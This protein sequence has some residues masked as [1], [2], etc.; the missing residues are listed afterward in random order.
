MTQTPVPQGEY[1]PYY[2]KIEVHWDRIPLWFSD[3][4]QIIVE[5]YGW[6]RDP[7]HAELLLERINAFLWLMGVFGLALS[8]PDSTDSEAPSGTLLDLPLFRGIVSTPTEG[9]VGVLAGLSVRR[10]DDPGNATNSGLAIEPYV[11]GSFDLPI[12]LTEGWN[13]AIGAELGAQGLALTIQPS[14]ANIVLAGG[15]GA[16]LRVG[17]QRDGTLLG[18]LLLFGN[19]G[20]TRLEIAQVGIALTASASTGGSPDV[21][22]EIPTQGFQLVIV[23]SEGDGFLKTVLPAEPLII[24]FDLMIGASLKRGVYFSGGAGFDYTFNINK[25]V[26]AIFVDSIDLGLKLDAKG[27][28]LSVGATGGLELGPVVAVIQG[29]GIQIK[30]TFGQRGNLGNA[31]LGILFKPPTGIGLSIDTPT[32]KAGGFLSIDVDRGRYVGA[33]ELSILN[34]FDLAAIAIITT[35]SPDG[36]PGFSLLFLIS[37]TLPVPVPLGYNFYFAGAGGLLGLNRGVDIDYLREGLR[38]GT[39]DNILFP[40]DIVRRIDAIVLDLDGS[41]PQTEGQFLVGP[42]ALITWSSPPLIS[43]KL[44]LVIEIGSPVRIAI[45]GVLRATLPDAKDPVLD[46]KVA[47]LGTID[48]EAELLSFDASIFDSYI[49]RD[50]FKL[51]I[52]GDMAL[53]VS[54]GKQPDFVTSIGGFHPSFSPQAHLHLPAM[55]RMSLSL[56]KDNPRLSLSLYLAVTSNTVQCGAR[57]DFFF[58][59]SEF[60]VVGDFGFDVLF[61]FSPF[62][63]DAHVYA[64]LA[65]KS[66]NTDILSLRLDFNLLGP[67]PWIARG[68]ASFKILFF[69]V[70]VQFEKRFGE[71][72]IETLPDIEVLPALILELNR[73]ESW[74]AELT[75]GEQTLVVLRPLT[76]TAGTV[77]VDAVGRLTVGQRILPLDTDFSRFG[78]SRPNDAERVSVKALRIGGIDEAFIS[79]QDD[80]APAAF[81]EMSDSDKLAA[82]PFERRPSG[83]QARTGQL[84]VTDAVIARPVAYEVIVSDSVSGASPTPRIKTPE[85]D[86]TTF[87]RLAAGGAA[88]RSMAARDNTRRAE[89]GKVLNLGSARER[90]VVASN[91]DLRPLAADGQPAAI[92]GNDAGGRPVYASG[93]LIGRTDAEQRR[94]ALLA[95]GF[96]PDELEIVPEAQLAA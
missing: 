33:I 7:F 75:T 54:W 45:L 39:A 52:E 11:D 58:K 49:G 2:D 29:I 66:G 61:Q 37:M 67:N 31:D 65:V 57:L 72:A 78:I 63:I 85:S 8:N 42:M 53:R 32:V 16:A 21:G 9:L 48:I 70:S 43:V 88:G 47:F 50:S 14:G 10:L 86:A 68:T 76:P 38:T 20:G 94:A 15:A 4:G 41:F 46:L 84:L 90:F 93:T 79:V 51:L 13:L 92:T 35:Q 12:T 19:S 17:L 18:P 80:F 28:T 3:P 82:A 26:G 96:S 30:G 64:G 95:Q 71:E 83:V 24:G 77:V 5:E 55:R 59:V 89:A 81:R 34:K 1:N 27:A 44:G 60:S 25:E 22:F 40:T 62:H 74:R 36:S 23:A 69:K 56:L 91:R 87:D 73:N 6:G